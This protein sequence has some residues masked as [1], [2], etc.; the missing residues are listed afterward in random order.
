MELKELC[1]SILNGD[2]LAL[3]G[4]SVNT[5]RALRAYL[6]GYELTIAP[7]LKPVDMSVLIDSG[8]DCEF[9]EGVYR[10]IGSLHSIDDGDSHKYGLCGT[11]HFHQYCRP[12]L[13]YWHSCGNM[14]NESAQI[15]AEK[16][17]SAG[18]NCQLGFGN[19]SLFID[20]ER[21]LLDGHCYPWQAS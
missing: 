1:R 16:L 2:N 11:G 18:F 19:M 5:E 14:Q 3:N 9:G 10:V 8:I 4:K 13:D 12:R 7:T 21:P 15:M 6:D 20:A 17:F